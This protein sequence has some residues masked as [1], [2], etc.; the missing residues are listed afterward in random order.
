MLCFAMCTRLELF[1]GD[2]KGEI[3]EVQVQGYDNVVT[4]AN[5]CIVI[6]AKIGKIYVTT[7]TNAG[8]T[9]V[10]TVTVTLSDY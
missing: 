1:E 5:Y 4:G 10:G 6:D 3:E 7:A 2:K 8:P 9:E